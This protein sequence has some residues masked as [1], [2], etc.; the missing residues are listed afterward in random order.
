MNI[1]AL[2][3]HCSVLPSH[4]NAW[5][6]LTSPLFQHGGVL[7]ALY[8]SDRLNINPSLHISALP[9]STKSLAVF[10]LDTDA[11]ICARI[12]WICWDLPPTTQIQV[13]ERR[14]VTGVND[15]QLK[16]YIGPCVNNNSHK[17]LF[18]MFAL[19]K[20]LSLP[21][22]TSAFQ[23]ERIMEPYILAWGTILFFSP[24][25]ANSRC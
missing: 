24:S 10:L 4:H 16:Q 17:Y 25:P 2:Y 18:V 12:H 6:N 11:P 5:L 22:S 14:G 7:P 15:F 8:R 21:D 1:P 23:V 3:H 13:N 19:S 20:L 9:V